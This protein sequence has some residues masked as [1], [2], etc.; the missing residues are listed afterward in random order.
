MET[1][2]R[3]LSDADR[4]V[5]A[6]LIDE[7]VLVS[8]DVIRID[9]NTWAIHGSIAVDGNELVAEFETRADAEAALEQ[10]AAALQETEMR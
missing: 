6:E 9:E 3:D 5:V 10:I 2:R 1:P 8:Y 4:R 7:H